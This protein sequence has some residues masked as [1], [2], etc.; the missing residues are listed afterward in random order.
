MRL[1]SVE[2]FVLKLRC[3]SAYLGPLLDG[4]ELAEAYEVREPWLSLYSSRFETMLVKVTAD[5]G[6]VGWGEALAPVAPEVP[7]L[8]VDLLLTPTALTIE[9]DDPRRAFAKLSGLMRERGHLVGHQADA[10]AAVDIAL[11]DLAARN[12]IVPVAAMLATQVRP[13]VGSYLSGLPV[14]GDADR[15]ALARARADEGTTSVKLH[16]GFGVDKDIETVRRLR[17]DVPDLRIAVDAHWVYSLDEATALAEGLAELGAWFLEAPMAPEDSSLV[18]L[19]HLPIAMGEALRNRYEFAQW[20]SAGAVS[21]IQPDVAR[22]GITEASAILALATE[23]GVPVS[24]HHSVGMGVA[25]AAGVQVAASAVAGTILEYQPSSLKVG[26]R[27][28]SQPMS[29]DATGYDVPTTAGL[30]ITVDESAVR[31]LAEV[32][33]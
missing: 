20:L 19:G 6:T 21:L 24:L 7:A 17:A 30:G 9:V 31:R 23:H 33:A 12:A 16:L 22:T 3:Q 13:R 27:I 28:L 10:L 11:W 8:I 4:T 2:T 32:R 25:L 14:N 18:A 26:N 29:V 1:T 5:N 15:V